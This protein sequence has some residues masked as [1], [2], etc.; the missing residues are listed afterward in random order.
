VGLVAA[1][2]LAAVL[3][4][5]PAR[6]AST[7]ASSNPAPPASTNPASSSS[8]LV[9]GES[10]TGSTPLHNNGTTGATVYLR[11]DHVTGA[12]A[13]ELRYTIGLQGVTGPVWSGSIAGLE[14]GILID[15]G[16][17]PGA[18][19]TCLF[20][21]TLPRD[22]GNEWEG[23]SATFDEVFTLEGGGVASSRVVVTGAAPGGGHSHGGLAFTGAS[24]YSMLVL[25]GAV[26]LLGAS[27]LVASMLSAD[28]RRRHGLKS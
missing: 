17:P 6:A 1:G 7:S 2:V 10:R 18:T 4:A 15:A 20:T 16:L 23:T 5:S 26:L 19:V 27:I 3:F 28:R 12:L 11:L 21:E 13:G 24:L 22:A 14:Q 25:A 8:P 9:P